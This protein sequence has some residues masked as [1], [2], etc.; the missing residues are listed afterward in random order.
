MAADDCDKPD[1]GGM[2]IE[3]WEV[4]R[5]R[6]VALEQ[7]VQLVMAQR[8]VIFASEQEVLRVAEVFARYLAPGQH[9][10]TV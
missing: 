9:A 7:A 3:A 4:F 2:S 5:I 10:E 6:T 8:R 1:G